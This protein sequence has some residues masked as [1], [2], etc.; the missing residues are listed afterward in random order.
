MFSIDIQVLFAGSP[1]EERYAHSEIKH[2][3]DHLVIPAAG[4]H[5]AVKTSGNTEHSKL[6]EAAGSFLHL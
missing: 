1:S 2:Y 5:R 3:K 6:P 4:W